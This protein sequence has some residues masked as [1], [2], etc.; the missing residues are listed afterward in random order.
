MPD[1]ITQGHVY[2]A[3]PPLY[4]AVPKKGRRDGIRLTMTRHLTRY[5]AEHEGRNFTLQRYKGLGEMDAQQLMGDNAESRKSVHLK[6]IEIEDARMASDITSML[7]GSG[8]T[9]SQTVHL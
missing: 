7:M 3:T 2:L 8:R 4:K 1:L 6:Q 9:T 5:R